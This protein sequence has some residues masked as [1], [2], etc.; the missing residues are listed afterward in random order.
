ML[1][2]TAP[3]LPRSLDPHSAMASPHG[4]STP[5]SQP[6]ALGVDDVQPARAPRAV[7]YIAFFVAV[8]ASMAAAAAVVSND[9]PVM[10]VGLM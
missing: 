8:L 6:A 10:V 1:H 7:P 4:A 3:E 5:A 9:M 2:N